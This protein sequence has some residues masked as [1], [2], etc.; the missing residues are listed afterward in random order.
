MYSTPSAN[1]VPSTCF[2]SAALAPNS[3]AAKAPSGNSTGSSGVGAGSSVGSSAA[4]PVVNAAYWNSIVSPYLMISPLTVTVSPTFK[5]AAQSPF[6]RNTKI[7]AT[8][9]VKMNV[10]F[11][12]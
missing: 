3:N 1:P 5:V 4:S 12:N 11:L 6:E 2:S 8:P 7:S 10:I 9:S